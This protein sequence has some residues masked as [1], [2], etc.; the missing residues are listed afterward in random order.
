MGVVPQTD[1]SH[2]FADYAV[3][4][5]ATLDLRYLALQADTKVGGLAVLSKNILGIELDKDWRV[6]CSDWEANVLT[7]Q[8]IDYAANDSHVAIEIFRRLF[9]KVNKISSPT[10]PDLMKYNKSFMDIA[11]SNKLVMDSP[12]HQKLLKNKE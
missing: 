7:K 3:K 2:L 12:K 11:F 1:A 9:S 10:L 6:S 4:M 8:Q 5:N